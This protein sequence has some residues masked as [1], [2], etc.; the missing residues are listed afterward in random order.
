MK[1]LLTLLLLPLTALGATTLAPGTYTVAACPVTP[2]TCTPPQ[3]LTNG[4]CTTPVPPAG[5]TSWVYHNGT[6]YWGG[7]YSFGGITINYQDTQGMPLSGSFDISASLHGQWGGF[8]PF[9]GGTVPLWN[10]DDSPYTY[11]TFAL[12]P[13]RV[14]QTAQV[15]FVKVGDVPV[16]IVVDPFSGKY[17]PAPQAGVWGTYKIPLAVLG[18]LKTSVYKFAIQDQTGTSDNVFYLDNIGFTN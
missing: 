1:I 11:L 16:G 7:D 18:V 3:V 10:F 9:A 12:K 17:G 6:L 2:P 8:L 5:G 4:V 15:Y 14:G 13:T